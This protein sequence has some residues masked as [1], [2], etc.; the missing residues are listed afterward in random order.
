MEARRN[1][2]ITDVACLIG[3][4]LFLRYRHRGN[5]AED[6]DLGLRLTGDGYRLAFLASTRIIHSH[7]RPAYY[8]LKRSYV[9]SLALFDLLPGFPS[10]PADEAAAVADDIVYSC[11]AL[12]ESMRGPL[13]ALLPP[14]SPRAL[15][16]AAAFGLRSKPSAPAGAPGEAG[17][18]LDAQT[19]ALVA[20][21]E[22]RF[23]PDAGAERPRHS[24]VQA[25]AIARMLCAYLEHAGRPIDRH[26]L[27]DFKSA[28]YKGWAQ[29]CGLRLAYLYWRGP[30]PVR[31]SLRELHEQMARGV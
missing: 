30:D 28:L 17:N 16:E 22:E 21:L 26:L 25:A 20:G 18:Y 29:T 11:R 8:H 1:G 2:Q 14:L 3:R 9:E 13:R 23:R 15:R 31:E 6:L 27:E 4:E 24:L 10:G 5:Y 7:N 12:D 19:R